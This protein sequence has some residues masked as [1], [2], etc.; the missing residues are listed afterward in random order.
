[1]KMFQTVVDK[2]IQLGTVL[3]MFVGNLLEGLFITHFKKMGNV[4]FQDKKMIL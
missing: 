2:I 3:L 1:M 4:Y